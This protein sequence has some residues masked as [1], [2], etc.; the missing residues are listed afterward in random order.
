[1]NFIGNGVVNTP[2]P[3][4]F[5]GVNNCE[6]KYPVVSQLSAFDMI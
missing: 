3:C 5:L 1:M 6:K 4:E 2:C